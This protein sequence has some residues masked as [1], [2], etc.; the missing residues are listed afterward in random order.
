MTQTSPEG[1]KPFERRAERMFIS[2]SVAAAITCAAIL[3]VLMVQMD[4]TRAQ[5]AAD[6]VLEF[7]FVQQL[8]HN[9]DTFANAANDL[10]IAR[11][12]GADINAPLTSSSELVRRFDVLYSTVPGIDDRWTGSLQDEPTMPITTLRV[13]EFVA[14]NE[15]RVVAG[16]VLANEELDQLATQGKQLAVAIYELGLVMY[17]RKSALRDEIGARMDWLTRASWFFGSTLLLAGLTLYLLL[18]RS[19]RRATQLFREARS[20]QTQLETAL[21]EVTSSDIQRKSRNAFLAAA[22]HDLRQPIQAVQY[23][24]AALDAHVSTDRGRDILTTTGR[25][26]D[27]AQRML[28]D[29]LD[30]SRLDDGVLRPGPG[31]VELDS[32][33]EHLRGTYRAEAED[34]GLSLVIP[35]TDVWVHTDPKFLERILGNLVGN[36]LAHT[37][38]GTISVRTQSDPD[39]TTTLSV[40]DTGSGIPA[41]EI[42]SIYHEYYQVGQNGTAQTGQLNGSTAG[43]GLGLCIVRRLTRLLDIPIHVSSTVGE[44]SR[45]WVVLPTVTPLHGSTAERYA[46]R[47]EHDDRLDGLA[48][49]IIDDEPAVRHG[50]HVLLEQHGCDVLPASDIEEAKGLLIQTASVPDL[51][52]ADYQLLNGAT[53]VDAIDIVR[54]EVNED[55]PAILITGDTSPQ[56]ATEARALELGL[57]HKPINKSEL[58]SAIRSALHLSNTAGLAGTGSRS[59]SNGFDATEIA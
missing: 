14:N 20:T 56:R 55:V 5:L 29:L 33:L 43:M 1:G 58:F 8:D 47:D 24:L 35:E 12:D 26:T 51:I 10:R 21:E 19:S 37:S 59:S 9:F 52:L 54:D 48:I 27:S 7:N 28:N 45:F 53:G 38:E 40:E 30:V 46:K 22:T 25:S 18:T 39:G 6:G 4:R 31:S 11:A 36:A 3:I 42:E 23:L 17:Q 16:A 57:L 32:V 34:R 2:I 44:G 41:D 50:M 15:D 49:M 13:T